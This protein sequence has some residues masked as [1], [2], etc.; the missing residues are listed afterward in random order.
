MS[1]EELHG[2]VVHLAECYCGIAFFEDVVDGIDYGRGGFE[3]YDVALPR[4]ARG[5]KEF[6]IGLSSSRF[7]R[8]RAYLPES[9][10]NCRLIS[11]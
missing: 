10:P 2:V 4:L 6:V 11:R 8:Y 7:R 1:G 3:G 5:F 9:L